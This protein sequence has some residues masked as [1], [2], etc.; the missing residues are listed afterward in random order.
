M[1]IVIANDAGNEVL[2]HGPLR[3]SAGYASGPLGEIRM[4]D[5]NSVEISPLLRSAVAVVFDRRNVYCTCEFAATREFS[6]LF[7]AKQWLAGHMIGVRRSHTL[8][9]I[10][11]GSEF[12]LTGG[13]LGPIRTSGA[14]V[15]ITLNYSF[16]FTGV[17]A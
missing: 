11:Q 8:R 16:I 7:A 10:D 1:Q 5:Q 17:E 3:A 15:E 9:I 2:V 13:A 4:V 6:G 12:R 14:G